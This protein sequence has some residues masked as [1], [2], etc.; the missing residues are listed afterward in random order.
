[1]A[2]FVT[3][4]RLA[5]LVPAV[6]RE[7]VELDESIAELRA[8]LGDAAYDAAADRGGAL[9]FDQIVAFALSSIDDLVRERSST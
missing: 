5:D 6:F 1:M 7:R 4:G 9:D 3:Q 2:G 8:E